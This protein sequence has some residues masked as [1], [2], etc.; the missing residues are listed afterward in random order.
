MHVSATTTETRL[1]GNYVNGG[2]GPGDPPDRRW[3]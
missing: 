3:T 1:L 2:V